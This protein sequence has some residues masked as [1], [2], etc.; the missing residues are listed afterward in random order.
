VKPDVVVTDY[1]LPGMSG[2]DFVRHYCGARAH[3]LAIVISA[4][5]DERTM[6]EAKDAGASFMAKPIDHQMLTRWV[7][8]ASV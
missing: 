8:Q 7:R 5:T 2:A 1:R 4:H 3:V 6:R